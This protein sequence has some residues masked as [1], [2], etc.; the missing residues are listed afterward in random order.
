M[1]RTS[2]QSTKSKQGSE[3]S[4]FPLNELAE[5]DM[6]T[7]VHAHNGSVISGRIVEF[8]DDHS[9]W[10]RPVHD[11]IVSIESILVTDEEY[12]VGNIVHKLPS[13]RAAGG[14]R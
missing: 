6:V 9:A 3:L 1:S 13:P 2:K 8:L 10:F 12:T 7:L 14:R 4:W 5:G 11:N